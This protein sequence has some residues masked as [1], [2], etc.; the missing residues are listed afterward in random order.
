M[1]QLKLSEIKSVQESN[2]SL[3]SENRSYPEPGS[4]QNCLKERQ[5]H[6]KTKSSLDEAIKL[7]S[8]L[9]EEL[10]RMDLKV[11]S[12]EGELNKERRQDFYLKQ[13]AIK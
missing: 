3:A 12:L 10:K 6:L 4:C 13:E 2:K 1:K 8:F 11:A 7:S 5:L 9:L